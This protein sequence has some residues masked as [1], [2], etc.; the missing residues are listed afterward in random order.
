[1]KH[2]S[3]LDCDNDRDFLSNVFRE[4]RLFLCLV[5]IFGTSMMVWFY[6]NLTILPHIACTVDL[7]VKEIVEKFW[8]NLICTH[9]R[10]L[11]VSAIVRYIYCNVWWAHNTKRKETKKNELVIVWVREM[12]SQ[13]ILMAMGPLTDALALVFHWCELSMLSLFLHASEWAKWMN[14]RE[15]VNREL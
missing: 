3:Y 8:P 9:V 1:M 13:W 11:C 2:F 15:E 4:N 14:E 12:W 7:I 10:I 6:H 5:P